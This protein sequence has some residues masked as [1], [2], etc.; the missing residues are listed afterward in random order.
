M[1]HPGADAASVLLHPM[2]RA[3]WVG[4]LATAL[5]LIPAWQ[6]DGGHIVYSLV[7]QKHQRISLGVGLA[8]VGLGVYFWRGWILWGFVMVV[9][10][11]R[12]KHPPVYDPWETLNASR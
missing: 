4:F 11:L 7:P 2:A 12:F 8:L 1:F 6:L 5:N 9:L 10:S 3:A